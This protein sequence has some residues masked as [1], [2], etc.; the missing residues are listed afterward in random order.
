MATVGEICNREVVVTTRDAT[1]ADAARLMRDH[2]VGTVIIAEPRDGAQRPVGIITD[3]DLVVEIMAMDLDPRDVRVEEVMGRDLVIAHENDGIQKT[4]D[5]M[6]YRGV[7]RLPVLSTR[8]NLLGIVAADDLMKV[9]AADITAL[10]T[11]TTRERWREAA[12]RKPVSV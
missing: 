9:L 6:N 12:Q 2:H 5:V 11:I 10:A 4:L 7:R 3:R 1:V 8:G